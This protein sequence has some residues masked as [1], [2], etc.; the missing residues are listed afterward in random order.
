[1]IPP[2][3]LPFDLDALDPASP[4]VRTL[5]GPA[6]EAEVANTPGWR[7]ADLGAVNGHGNARSVGIEID[8][9]AEFA[10]GSNCVPGAVIESEGQGSVRFGR[11]V[12]ELDSP[13]GGCE[14]AR[15]GLTGRHERVFAQQ[16]V[17]VGEAD[18]S[19]RV[20]GIVND[21]LGEVVDRLT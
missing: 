9:A 14:G 20:I 10:L 13:S 19:G 11:L 17:A 12:V 3:P 16:V 1:M 15:V 7:R 5:T 8:G 6:I 21:G 18:I 4:T 2:P